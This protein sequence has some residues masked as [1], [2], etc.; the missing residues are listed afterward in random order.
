M[1][2]TASELE[3][4]EVMSE[5]VIVIAGQPDLTAPLEMV[6]WRKINE[7][8]KTAYYASRAELIA[9]CEWHSHAT[10]AEGFVDHCLENGWLREMTLE[11]N[12]LARQ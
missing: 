12:G 5:R 9:A 8:Y 4:S 1:Y 2:A 7:V 3:E 10:S 6:A 11:P